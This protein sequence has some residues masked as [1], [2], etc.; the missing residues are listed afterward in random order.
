MDA[1]NYFLQAAIYTKALK[2]YLSYIDPR[3]FSECFGGVIYIFLRGLSSSTKG[4]YHIPLSQVK[5][6]DEISYD[7]HTIVQ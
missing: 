3:P 2:T 6:I 5:N 4:I 1:N 7:T